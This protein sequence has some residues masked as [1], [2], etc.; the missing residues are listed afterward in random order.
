MSF[1]GVDP[2]MLDEAFEALEAGE[3]IDIVLSWLFEEAHTA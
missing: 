2:A 1:K 3:D